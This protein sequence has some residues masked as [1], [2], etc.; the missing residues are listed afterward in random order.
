MIKTSSNQAA[1]GFRLGLTRADAG[2]KGNPLPDGDYDVNVGKVVFKPST[3]PATKDSEVFIVEFTVDAIRFQ[4][5]SIDYNN[6]AME[7]VTEGE[8]RNWVAM[9]MHK[10]QVGRIREF[11]FAATGATNT[12]QGEDTFN[13]LC[14][15]IGVSAADKAQFLKDGTSDGGIDYWDSIGSLASS[16]YNPFA[17][18]TVAVQVQRTETKGKTPF[19]VYAWRPATTAAAA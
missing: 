16:Q 17:G 9:T 19:P 5:P 6:E 11:L 1:G 12:N 14:K 8:K 4:K 3:N 13:T 18:L 2:G 10:P 15:E 7:P